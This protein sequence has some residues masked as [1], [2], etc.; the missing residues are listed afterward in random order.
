MQR[1]I[2]Q[3]LTIATRMFL[4]SD[5]L[6]VGAHAWILGNIRSDSAQGK[7]MQPDEYQV[8]IVERHA[9][10]GWQ[11]F[12]APEGC[13]HG[14]DVFEIVVERE[15]WANRGFLAKAAKRGLRAVMARA[16]CD[17]FAVERGADVF[18]LVA[19]EDEGE[20]ACLLLGGT[21]DAEARNLHQ[22]LRGID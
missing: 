19:V 12:E 16:Y 10:S 3:S 18:G 13:D 20:N 17:T 9:L 15:R 1:E 22:L 6:D 7:R 5:N 2:Q 8:E 11:L 21:D 4:Q 14:V